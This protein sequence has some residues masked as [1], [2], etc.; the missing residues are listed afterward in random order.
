[1][2]E[3]MIFPNKKML[4]SLSLMSIQLNEFMDNL[5][6]QML[7]GRTPNIGSKKGKRTVSMIIYEDFVDEDNGEVVSVERTVLVRH[8][9]IFYRN[10]KKINL[11]KYILT[12]IKF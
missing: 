4:R 12:E 2:P 8:G 5:E 10:G 6:K 1:M 3:N 7:H 11:K 9:N